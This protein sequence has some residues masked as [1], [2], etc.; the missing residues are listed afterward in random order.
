MSNYIP[1]SL[2]L[3]DLVDQVESGAIQLPDFQRPFVWTKS[4]QKGLIDSLQKGYPVGSLLFLEIAPGQAANSPFGRKTFDQ[5]NF[6]ELSDE[7]LNNTLRYLVLD[8]Q[9][10]MTTCFLAFSQ[11]SKAKKWH[12]L[13]VDKLFEAVGGRANVAIDFKEFLVYKQ[14]DVH[15]QGL[16]LTQNLLALPLILGDRNE[17]RTL[18]AMYAD[19]LTGAGKDDLA[20]FTRA[21]LHSYFDE[22]HSYQFPVVVLPSS[23]NLEAVANVFTQL[24]TSGVRLSAFDLCVS[25]LFPTGLRLR[26]MWD[27]VRLE[28]GVKLLDNDGTGILQTIH[29]RAGEPVKKSAL[30]NSVSKAVIESKWQT[31]VTGFDAV[32]N[33]LHG[34]GVTSSKT[35]PYD[36]VGPAIVAAHIEAGAPIGVQAITDRASK[37]RRWI[38]QTGLNLRYTE[39]SDTKKPEDY[40]QAVNWFRNNEEPRFLTPV[41]WHSGMQDARNNGARYKVLLSMLNQKAPRDFLQSTTQLGLD[42]GRHTQAEIHHIFPKAYVGSLPGLTKKDADKM[43]NM[44]FLTAESNRLISDNKP[45]VYLSAVIEEWRLTNPHLSEEQA[46]KNLKEVLREHYIDETGFAALQA[47]DFAGFLRARANTFKQAVIG[48]GIPV[49]TAEND[50]PDF[51][52]E[53]EE[54]VDSE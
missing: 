54:T 24:N 4:N 3:K 23:L 39:G 11:Q 51:D 45:S 37:I 33:I 32:H 28:P 40:S 41:T 5:A 19:N 10:R 53:D 38:I 48:V 22:L 46:L 20:D 27:E 18:L 12:F 49:I 21:N 13:Q 52:E 6:P 42:D 9:Q 26:T 14:K 1:L 47:D 36:S 30:V 17:L 25:R 15:P 44:T 50:S 34:F 29:L 35:L 43:F 7:A 16:L 8:G 2:K 31:T